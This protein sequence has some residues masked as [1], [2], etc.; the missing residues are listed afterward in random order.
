MTMPKL[1]PRFALATAAALTLSVPAHAGPQENKAAALRFYDAYAVSRRGSAV[2]RPYLAPNF[3]SHSPFLTAT[4]VDAFLKTADDLRDGKLG[5]IVVRTERAVADGDLVILHS[6]AQ[7]NGATLAL[8]DIYR[9]DAQGRIAE[10]WDVLQDVTKASN[11][12]GS[13]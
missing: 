11:P 12:N 3:R 6:R 4:T 13:F 8:V 1:L 10:H 2:L 9:F 7:A 5:S